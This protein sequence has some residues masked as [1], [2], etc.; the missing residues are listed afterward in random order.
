MSFKLWD[1]SPHCDGDCQTNTVEVH[2]LGGLG[3]RI[4]DDRID[5]LHPKRFDGRSPLAITMTCVM[6]SGPN[7]VRNT[8]TLAGRRAGGADRKCPPVFSSR[9]IPSGQRSKIA[10]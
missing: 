7:A 8:C 6:H 3:G 4:A 10:H 2:I 5:A 1:R 9:T